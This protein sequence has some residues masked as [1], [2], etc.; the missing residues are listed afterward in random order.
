ML[1]KI[2][3]A[4]VVFFCISLEGKKRVRVELNDGAV[5]ESILLKSTDQFIF[6]DL[7]FEVLKIP[8]KEVSAINELNHSEPTPAFSSNE[9][10]FTSSPN[11][12]NSPLNELVRE[13]GESVVMVRTPTGLGSGF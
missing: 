8:Q 9:F 12:R 6:L 4:T 7:D 11:R 2:T 1:S 13:L 10:L 5:I 3:L